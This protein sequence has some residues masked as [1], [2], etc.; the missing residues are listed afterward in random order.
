[1][2]ML[3]RIIMSTIV[4]GGMMSTPVFAQQQ[5]PISQSENHQNVV[6]INEEVESKYRSKYD[7]MELELEESLNNN[8]S[9]QSV[10]KNHD[11]TSIYTKTFEEEGSIIT[12][13]I[14]YSEEKNNNDGVD[15]Y[16]TTEIITHA[17]V[18]ID[19]DITKI[20]NSDIDMSL[21]ITGVE[22]GVTALYDSAR[23]TNINVI[24]RQ[25][26]AHD[27]S[28]SRSDEFD[29]R[30]LKYNKSYSWPYI[31]LADNVEI[32]GQIVQHDATY[33]LE[34]GTSTTEDMISHLD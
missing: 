23:L 22:G 6:I 1:M 12:L 7:E 29:T 24:V 16:A 27:S 5:T 13:G 9:L 2:K 32:L 34:R 10:R 25:A 14:I 31:T 8:I 15:T 26:A 21:K 17:K 18:Y 30:Q 28:N 4:V 11:D 19:T 20:S 3:K 33:T